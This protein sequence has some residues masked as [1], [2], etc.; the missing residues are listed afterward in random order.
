[1][2]IFLFYLGGCIDSCRSIGVYEMGA[3]DQNGM[4]ASDGGTSHVSQAER[5]EA[6]LE[7]PDALDALIASKTR[8]LD[9]GSADFDGELSGH[10]VFPSGIGIPTATDNMRMSGSRCLQRLK[11]EKVS[12]EKPQFETP[13]IDTPVLLAGP[14][15]EVRIGPRY[16]GNKRRTN[17]VMDCHLAL[18]LVAVARHAKQLGISTIEFYSTYRP[19]KRPPKKC[20]KGK[21]RKKCLKKVR[22]YRRTVKDQKSQ[23][24]FGRAIDIR[25]LQTTSEQKLDVLEHFER[26]SGEPPCSYLPEEENA[27]LLS[28]FVCGLYHYRV[29]N[30]MLTPN[31]N[32]AHHNHF[33]FDVTPGAKWNIV[34]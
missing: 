30:V 20:P 12:F 25:W 13:L 6:L 31:A 28:Q 23:H 29:F 34:R 1:M 2:L 32:K 8:S 17:A 7:D 11:E 16:T 15:E 26:R 19:L 33:H 3:N 10:H 22:A 9:E 14:I 24:R 21:G 27:K 18:A 4:S 5:E